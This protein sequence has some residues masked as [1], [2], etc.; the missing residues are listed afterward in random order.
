MKPI[1]PKISEN[2]NSSMEVKKGFET[3]LFYFM[4][5]ISY[6][7][8]PKLNGYVKFS[9]ISLHQNGQSGVTEIH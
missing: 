6:M 3:H 7:I 2:S 1:F 4:L 9:A 8:L 5:N